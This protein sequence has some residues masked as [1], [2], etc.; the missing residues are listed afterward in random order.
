MN[1]ERFMIS[2]RSQ[3]S[4]TFIGY[5]NLYEIFRISKSIEIGIRLVVAQGLGGGE[6]SK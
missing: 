2:K 3:T 6:N 1:S 5:F 4:K